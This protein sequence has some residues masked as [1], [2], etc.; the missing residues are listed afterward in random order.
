MGFF[1]KSRQLV[2]AW[3]DNKIKRLNGTPSTKVDSGG[4]INEYEFRGQDID[5]SELRD[6]KQIRESGGVISHLVHAKALMQFG[7]GVE[8][9]TENEEIVEF[10]DEK[11][12]NVDNLL[13]D[14]GEDG[15]WYPFS[16]AELV[17]TRGGGFSHV[18][19]VEPW[20]LM[21]QTNEYGE[22]LAWEQHV[23]ASNGFGNEEVET[24]QPDEIA[25][26]ILNKS[27]ARDKTG[28][29]EVLRA[30]EEITQFRENREAVNKA[31]EIAGFPHH[32]W[33]VGEEGGPA[34]D[35][36]ELRRVRN[37]VDNMEGD[38]QFVMGTGVD[39]ELIQPG[40]FKFEAIQE[41]DLRE[42]ALALGLPLELANVGSDG[43]GSGMPADL[44][45][46]L[47]ER[48]AR[49]SQ[50]RIADQFVEQVA[51]VILRDYSPY[52]P[53]ELEGMTFGDPI[54]DREENSLTDLAPY[55]TLNE[56]REEMDK[57]PAEDDELGNSYRKPA[58]IQAPEEEE[59]EDGG[60]G[61][62][63]GEGEEGN[64]SLAD[65]IDTTHT[66]E[67][68]EHFLNLYQRI[69][70][71]ETD[72]NLV[73]QFDDYETPEMVKENLKQAIRGGAVFH[74]FDTIP[75]DQL[76]QLREYLIEELD[77]GNWNIDG[78]ANRLQDLDGDLS[79]DQA[80]TIARTETASAANSAREIAYKEKDMEDS[81]FYWT[82]ALDGRQTDAC[83]WLINKTNPHQGG[84][85]VGLEELKDLIEE[86]PTHDP[87]MQDD[88]A[89]PENFVVHPNER[90]TW[91]RHVE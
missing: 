73:G 69:W 40:E 30:E 9:Q 62:I 8:W 78:I 36:N 91:V 61:D 25:T 12:P 66:P 72:R 4:T 3:A 56:I 14:L 5:R 22:V 15:I 86:A 75:S 42:V 89:R 35:D 52:N 33:K 16:G 23:Q 49:A 50:R 19:P 21:P 87:D 60:I 20:T 39:H 84:N 27:S 53:D 51:R 29:S 74:E 80:Q 58:N 6:V 48:Q 32:I 71:V 90:K 28:I 37:R 57:P 76:M 10:L 64:L 55:M 18:E 83:E 13:I 82:G 70:S 65:G 81:K 63:F 11:I 67:W 46:T 59:P 77:D 45:L 7:T 88:L 79:F 38:T 34:I 44:R 1:G 41:H 26:F 68:D 47:F 43:L 24:F 31:I 54:S 2:S 17:E 85:P